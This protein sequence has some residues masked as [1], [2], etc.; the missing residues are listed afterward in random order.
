VLSKSTRHRYRNALAELG[1][2]ACSAAKTKTVPMNKILV[3][4]RAITGAD[5]PE[6]YLKGFNTLTLVRDK[7]RARTEEE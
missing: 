2:L 1:V 7:K 6:R 3:P 5:L 4:A